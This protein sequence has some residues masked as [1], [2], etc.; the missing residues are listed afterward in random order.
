MACVQSKCL[1]D[2]PATHVCVPTSLSLCYSATVLIGLPTLLFGAEDCIDAADKAE[3]IR[4]C[5]RTSA[6]GHSKTP[7]L[8]LQHAE[9]VFA[10]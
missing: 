7:L 9:G 1:T 2:T 10:A 4:W 6:A 5:K 8:R 3:A